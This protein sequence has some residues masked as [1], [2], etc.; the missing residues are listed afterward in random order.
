MDIGGL[1][2]PDFMLDCIPIFPHP[3]GSFYCVIIALTID[4]M[5]HS[6][7]GGRGL[8][9]K[10]VAEGV[11]ERI[12]Y[13]QCNGYKATELVSK[14]RRDMF[15]KDARTRTEQYEYFPFEVQYLADRCETKV[16]RQ[17]SAREMQDRE[18]DTEE[19]VFTIL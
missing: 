14:R 8:I 16:T 9:L 6:C 15:K 10:L 19:V 2:C 18:V 17:A 13:F 3:V 4:W 12:G 7:L 1:F 5:Q 11:Y